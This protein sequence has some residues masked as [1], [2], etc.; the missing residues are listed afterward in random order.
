MA[1]SE[2]SFLP[3][4][5]DCA[6]TW[7]TLR[8][9]DGPECLECGSA[10]VVV[11]DWDYLSSLRRYQCRECGRWFNDRSGTFLENSEVRL[12]VWI[13]VLREMNKDRTINS[14]AKDLLHTC[15]TVRRIAATM[16]E[17]IDKRRDE[18]PEILTREVETDDVH[19][20][21]SQKGQILCSDEASEEAGQGG[22]ESPAVWWRD[23]RDE[24]LRL[25]DEQSPR[26][27]YDAVTLRTRS[28]EVQALDPLDQAFYAVKANPHPDVLRVLERQG[29][30]FE[31][32]SPGELERVFEVLPDLD[33]GRVLFQPNFAAPPEYADAF[34]RGVHV[35][36]DNVQ[37]LVEHPGVF[38]GEEIFVRV[39]PGQGHGHHRKVRTAGAQS[40]FGVVPGD[41]GRLREAA[42]R[43]GATVVGLHAHV[44]SG[45]TE[46]HMWADLLDLL[47]S[48]A[49]DFPATHTI[50][51]G[52]GL[53]VAEQPGGRPFDLGALEAGLGEAADRHPQQTLWMEPGRYLVAE[54]GVLLARVTQTK[55]KEPVRYVGLDTGMN[56]LLRP[57][58]YGAHHEIVNLSRLGEA[59]SMTA[60]VVGPI[61]ET[62]DV[63]GND[64]RLPPTKPGDTLLVASAG[65]YG[66]SM[67][68]SYNLR[69]PAP[70]HFLSLSNPLDRELD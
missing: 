32:V 36:V 22:G 48:L 54:A 15:K 47:A 23:R 31:C 41:L 65:A 37:P 51:V 2:E 61:C 13:Y 40:K 63:L 44:G 26:Y 43:A 16:R 24:L 21:L 25:A 1:L 56:S 69:P 4:E 46:E 9:P 59:P 10:D 34:E 68:N 39:D 66:A 5:E 30:G 11:Q 38:A 50:N 67:S 33:P 29:L 52:G 49:A 55:T 8:W 20:N 60:D 45:V 12:P 35:T 19:L 7:R 62:G 17:A 53:A 57:A 70:E 42:D 3:D 18:W 27:V 28:R 6:E 64:R 14:I 58:L